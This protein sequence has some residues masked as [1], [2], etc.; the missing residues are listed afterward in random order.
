MH[1]MI[2]FLLLL[3]VPFC[4]AMAQETP[5]F[6]VFGGYSFMSTDL[7]ETPEVV[8]GMR[9]GFQGWNV[10]LTWYASHNVGFTAD[11]SGH[12][13][14]QNIPFFGK[15]TA[16]LYSFAFGPKLVHH[17]D[18]F[19]MF[20]HGLFGIQRAEIEAPPEFETTNSRTISDHDFGMVL[21]GGL[22]YVIKKQCAFR[23][24]QFDYMMGQ[25]FGSIE[26]HI[27]ISTGLTYR[28]KK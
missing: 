15:T 10:A 18:N 28:L 21:G 27:R 19:E 5:R 12:Y 1:R 25:L 23:V 3:L 22:D 6:D 8:P 7:L 24:V 14:S 11:F 9:D 20:V 16:N 13:G 2:L 26:N 4:A 17:A